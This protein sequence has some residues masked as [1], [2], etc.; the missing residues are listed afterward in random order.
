MWSSLK[1]LP[2]MWSPP[3]VVLIMWSSLKVVPTLWC[4]T[5][6][7]STMW[8]SPGDQGYED[9]AIWTESLVRHNTMQHFHD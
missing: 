5:K 1:V 3:K 8:Y 9:H 7:V 4:P 2:T 6:V